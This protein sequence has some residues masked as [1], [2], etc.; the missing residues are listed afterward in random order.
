[1]VAELERD[2]RTGLWTAYLSQGDGVRVRHPLP[3]P[4]TATREQAQD[5]C[6]RLIMRLEGRCGHEYRC[7]HTAR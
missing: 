5:A 4:F 1:M 6:E 2:R 7:L 3:V